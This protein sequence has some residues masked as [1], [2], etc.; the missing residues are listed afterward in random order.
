MIFGRG[1]G[2]P[3]DELTW[4]FLNS[5]LRMARGNRIN[6]GPNSGLSMVRSEGIG[7][8]LRLSQVTT[9]GQL[10]IT[11][12]TISANVFNTG[13]CM[14]TSPKKWAPGGGTVHFV[15][16]NGTCWVEDDTGDVNVLNFST[17]TGGIPSDTLVWL[18]TD[19]GGNWV[20]TAVDCGN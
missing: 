14:G 3:G 12:S 17:T 5:L 7:T 9:T 18:S 11:T 1:Y 16:Y 4:N 20:I 15:N 19:A 8:F 6:L 10:A 13:S 2:R